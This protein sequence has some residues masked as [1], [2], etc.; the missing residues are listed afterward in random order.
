MSF[1]KQKTVASPAT[2]EGTSLHTGQAV[3]LTLKPAPV[4]SGF[5]FRRIDLPDQ[6]FIKADIEKVQTVERATSLAEGSVKVHTVEHI[7]SA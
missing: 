1:G 3:K 7:L 2:L 4:D 5:K 6:P